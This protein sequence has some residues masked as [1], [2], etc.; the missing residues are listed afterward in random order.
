MLYNQN[1]KSSKNESSTVKPTEKGKN[2]ELYFCKAHFHAVPV[3]LFYQ[4][5]HTF[6]FIKKKNSEL[7][8]I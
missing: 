3:S 5:E 2:E 1:E 6:Q 8:V 4:K 7:E